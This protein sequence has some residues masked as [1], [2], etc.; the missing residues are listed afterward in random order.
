[1]SGEPL[2][3]LSIFLVFLNEPIVLGLPVPLIFTELSAKARYEDGSVNF[4]E[5]LLIGLAI[6]FMNNL[7]LSPFS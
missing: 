5:H 1:M 4:N 6:S 3:R 2:F 7:P